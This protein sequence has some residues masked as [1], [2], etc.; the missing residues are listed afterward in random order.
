MKRFLLVLALVCLAASSA[1]AWP[2][3]T[4]NA[5]CTFATDNT[6]TA[7][8]TIDR[9]LKTLSVWVPTIESSTISVQV[10]ND[11]TTFYTYSYNAGAAAAPAVWTV[12]AATGTAAYELPRGVANFKYLRFLFGTG[13]TANRTL[14]VVG[15]E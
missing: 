15:Q 6:H 9:G 10:S 13:Q 5:V 1:F 2:S 3:V 4:K 11:G 8:V 14:V 7:A 12:G